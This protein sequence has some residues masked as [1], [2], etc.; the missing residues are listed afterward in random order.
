M[1][2]LCAFEQRIECKK[3]EYNSVIHSRLQDA[4]CLRQRER[5]HSEEASYVSF[6]VVSSASDSFEVW[7]RIVIK[8]QKNVVVRDF[9]KFCIYFCGRN[10]NFI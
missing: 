2:P 1:K 9:C 4:L 10:G 3:T 7:L 8:I 6:V 5:N